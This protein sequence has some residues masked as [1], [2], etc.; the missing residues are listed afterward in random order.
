M[1]THKPSTAKAAAAYL[2]AATAGIGLLTFLPA[3]VTTTANA[4][5]P[6][7]VA[8]PVHTESAPAPA[9]TPAPEVK[10]A[11]VPTAPPAPK[12]TPS[13]VH[14]EPAPV[15]TTAPAPEVTPSPVH[16]GSAPVPIGATCEESIAASLAWYTGPIADDTVTALHNA[17]AELGPD[18][19]AVIFEDGAWAVFTPDGVVLR[20]GCAAVE[21]LCAD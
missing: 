10:P 9:T 18:V 21:A 14:A 11:P 19:Q 1:T 7:A 6:K 13:P 15:P 2:I 20:S 12:A 8:A 4:P 17:C 16:T 5:E 3:S